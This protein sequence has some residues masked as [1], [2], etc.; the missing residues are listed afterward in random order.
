MQTI[1]LID[2]I[3]KH[4]K[5]K[6]DAAIALGSKRQSLNNMLNTGIRVAQLTDGTYITIN[7]SNKEFK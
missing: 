6:S 1:K 5:T 2:H 7:K 4:Y 3:D